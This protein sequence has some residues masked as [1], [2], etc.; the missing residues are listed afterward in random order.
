V[1]FL[2]TAHYDEHVDATINAAE[3][4]LEELGR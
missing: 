3:Q 2:S 4:V 1:L